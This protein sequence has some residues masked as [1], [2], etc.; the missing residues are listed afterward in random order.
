LQFAA[1]TSKKR[2]GSS[3]VGDSKGKIACINVNLIA[4]IAFLLSFAP[5]QEIISWLKNN[6]ASQN[7]ERS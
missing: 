1:A 3:L 5:S 4:E 7:P 6:L 2:S